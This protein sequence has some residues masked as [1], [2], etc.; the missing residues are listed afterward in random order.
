MPP[1]RPSS[2]A[3]FLAPAARP[4]PLGWRPG[5]PPLPPPLP[6]AGR[7][8]A[9]ALQRPPSAPPLLLSSAVSLAAAS[10][11]D[12]DAGP[13]RAPPP[14]PPPLQRS[15]SPPAGVQRLC[16]VLEVRASIRRLTQL[17]ERL[18]VVRA[19]A[20]AARRRVAAAAERRRQADLLQAAMERARAERRHWAERADAAE[21][22]LT[23]AR[24]AV[25]SQR[26]SLRE[27]AG[28]LV[29]GAEALQVAE[30]R[31]L[32]AE[33]ELGGPSGR[34]RLAALTAA[35]V[36]RRNRLV[37]A[38]GRIFQVGPVSADLLEPDPLD[39][40]IDSGWAG[41]WARGG[42]Q[43]GAAG[44]A[45]ATQAAAT[46][47]AQRPPAAAA[48]A[49]PAQQVPTRLAVVGLEVP[50]DLIQRSLGAAQPLPGPPDGHGSGGGAAASA[51]PGAE[52]RIFS[53][54]TGA[55]S[56]A[57]AAAAAVMAPAPAPP[58]LAVG[59]LPGPRGVGVGGRLAVFSAL[60][61]ASLDPRVSAT[62]VGAPCD[63]AH[64]AG[65][66]PAAGL[67]LFCGEGGRDRARFAYGV[68]LL[69]KDLEQLLEAHAVMAMG[70]VWEAKGRSGVETR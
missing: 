69:C 29:R 25:A 52:H 32:A 1:L 6:P 57:A 40:A 8:D 65:L 9:A 49:A 27:R 30:Q 35:L 37:A 23:A 5:S 18:D 16:D 39:V 28:A 20:R 58:P 60:L 45:G 56:G 41:E 33:A 2:Q 70:G 24:A 61:N 68:Y 11:G 31:R 36:G 44:P 12:P 66:H 46:P 63:D 55:L 26:A 21:A 15:A 4:A 34:G 14:Q 3:S 43:P 22:Q 42:H 38:L 54:A 62:P 7:P 17:Q 13:P 50:A 67:P 48:A 19:A 64:P 47:T 10:S 51:A 53:L 59:L